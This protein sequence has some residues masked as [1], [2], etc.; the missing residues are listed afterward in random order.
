MRAVPTRQQES[1]D[2]ELRHHP[3]VLVLE[4]VAVSHVWRSFRGRMVKADLDFTSPAIADW[5]YVLPAGHMGGG[6]CAVDLQYAEL[7]AMNVHGMKHAVVSLGDQPAQ[8]ALNG[9]R[10]RRLRQLE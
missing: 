1:G 10:E 8:I 5:R 2:D 7:A 6:R 9:H 4:N 3:G